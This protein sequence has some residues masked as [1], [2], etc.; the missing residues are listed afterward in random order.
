MA[1]EQKIRGNVMSLLAKQQ[2]HPG[3]LE[4]AYLTQMEKAGKAN[5][6]SQI[7]GKNLAVFKKKQPVHQKVI[8]NRLGWLDVIEEMPGEIRRMADLVQQVRE[9][10][11]C[12]VFVLGMGGSSLCPE[13]LGQ[14]FGKKTWLKNFTIV[15]TTAPSR[16]EA[17]IGATDIRKSFFIVSS[18]SGS[19]V[20]T[21]SQFRL[22]F[23]LIK[24][25]RPLKAG[26]H[27]AAISDEGSDLHRIARRNRFREIFLNRSDIG[28]RFSALSYFGLVPGAFTKADLGTLLE[29][30]GQQLAMMKKD[31]NRCDAL[32]LG[33]L[34]GIG[35]A[36]GYD[37]I[38]FRTT[39]SM[40][41]LITWI[42]QLVAESTGKE[43]K[44]IV[45]IEGNID[46]GAK[47]DDLIDVNYLLKG[48]QLGE[49]RSKKT[50]GGGPHVS[51]E[52]PELVSIGAE[53]MKWEMATTVA[54]TVMGVNPF[55]E[56]N[57][58]ESKKNT[59]SIL[60]AKRGPRKVVSIT[61]L[62]TYGNVDI[63]SAT[64]I[65]E[66]SH[67]RSLTSEDIFSGFFAGV[68]KGDFV[69]FLC[70]TEKAP[71]I[72]KLLAQLRQVI[73]SKYSLITL[74][75]Y[76]PRFLH[77]TGQLFKGGSP[78][79]HFVVFER[80]YK[81]DYDIPGQNLSFGRL[82]KAQ[83]QGDI[84][85]MRKRKRPVINIHLGLDPI[86][87]LNQIIKLVKSL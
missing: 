24:G 69:S 38:R 1:E 82:I 17:I 3:A 67:R 13:V 66:L 73:E 6:V 70:Y 19:T 47:S 48:E 54:A 34:M 36:T 46:G 25:V 23:R 7:I 28:G 26:L 74:R 39:P 51:I 21:M 80:E 79:G 53:M 11:L 77:S 27:F 68:G 40:A 71:D 59:T 61:P 45:P 84:K 63:V 49:M 41:P 81:T 9:D 33:V 32:K 72:E 22:F 15:D 16:L 43:S 86:G 12:H 83:A 44:G 29:G 87:G 78:K 42:E 14:V 58:A 85:A 2:V 76:G 50:G 64:G 52:V 55:D 4:K 10:G 30:A 56:P 65:K 62:A 75:G 35:A 20:E 31:G 37:R 60:H 57:V 8:L 5:L 18:K